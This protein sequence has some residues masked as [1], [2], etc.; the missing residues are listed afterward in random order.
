MG[1]WFE[2][3][4]IWMIPGLND[5]YFQKYPTHCFLSFIHF[6]IRNFFPEV[7]YRC[8]SCYLNDYRPKYFLEIMLT[9]QYIYDKYYS[10]M[11]HIYIYI[12]IYTHIYI[13]QDNIISNTFLDKRMTALS[14]QTKKT[15]HFWLQILSAFIEKWKLRESFKR[16][17]SVICPKWILFFS[18][19]LKLIVQSTRVYWSEVYYKVWRK[20]IHWNTNRRL[21]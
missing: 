6:R 8:V 10:Y 19:I 5:I 14:K 20:N 2:L 18:F 3:S 21:L 17:S 9:E 16:F 1:Q 12:Y 4:V 7:A 11:F 13:A 15:T